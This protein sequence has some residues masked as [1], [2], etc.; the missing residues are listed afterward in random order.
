MACKT[1]LGQPRTLSSMMRHTTECIINCPF[2]HLVLK[3]N[4]VRTPCPV[5]TCKLKPQGAGLTGRTVRANSKLR[6]GEY[7]GQL[8]F[9]HQFCRGHNQMAI[10]TQALLR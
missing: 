3:D 5:G 7:G 4:E 10:E 9:P 6:S 2:H 8:I 1:S